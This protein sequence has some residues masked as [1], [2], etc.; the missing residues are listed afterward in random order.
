MSIVEMLLPVGSCRSVLAAHASMCHLYYLFVTCCEVA[1][2]PRRIRRTTEHQILTWICQLH[3]LV[4]IA[5]AAPYAPFAL[6][7]ANE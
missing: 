7:W 1:T 5:D 2:G 4:L 3:V 6:G